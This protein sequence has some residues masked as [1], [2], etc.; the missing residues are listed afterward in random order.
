MMM[1]EK[2]SSEL[3]VKAKTDRIRIKHLGLAEKGRG[4]DRRNRKKLNGRVVPREARS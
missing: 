2:S 4:W 3:T 1:R